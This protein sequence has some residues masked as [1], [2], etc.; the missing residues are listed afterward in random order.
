LA[1]ETWQELVLTDRETTSSSGTLD[2]EFCRFLLIYEHKEDVAERIGTVDLRESCMEKYYDGRKVLERNKSP[3][4]R[5][6]KQKIRL[7]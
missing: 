6:E 5:L 7:G 4:M 3:I 1:A 2:I